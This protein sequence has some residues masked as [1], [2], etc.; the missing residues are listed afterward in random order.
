MDLK[1]GR[2]LYH[3]PPPARAASHRR[4]LTLQSN[5]NLVAPVVTPV[6]AEL[7][8]ILAVGA[9]LGVPLW[10]A[11]R[12]LRG[13]VGRVAQGVGELRTSVAQDIGKLRERM[14]RLEGLFEG[15][16]GVKAPAPA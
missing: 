6:S 1:C 3:L 14:A 13:E 10:A 2:L 11:M 7:I 8:A 16:A 9:A 15:Y 5:P 12:D 4:L